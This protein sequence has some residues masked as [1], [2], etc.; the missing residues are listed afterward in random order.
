MLFRAISISILSLFLTYITISYS[1][2]KYVFQNSIR[3]REKNITEKERVNGRE[4][5]REREKDTLCLFVCFRS[6][7]GSS[8]CL[9]FVERILKVYTWTKVLLVD[10]TNT[11]NRTYNRRVAV[12]WSFWKW[13]FLIF[14][15]FIL[16]YVSF[17]INENKDCTWTLWLLPL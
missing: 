4:R 6:L 8:Y 15:S 13:Y 11:E 10:K 9:I 17:S 14:F 3:Y 7:L 1:Q 2:D 16:Y 5:D 12:I